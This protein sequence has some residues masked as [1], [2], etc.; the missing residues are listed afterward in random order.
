MRHWEG[1]CLCVFMCLGGCVLGAFL[2]GVCLC[3]FLC[4]VSFVYLGFLFACVIG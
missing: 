2:A 1:F 3:V 4:V